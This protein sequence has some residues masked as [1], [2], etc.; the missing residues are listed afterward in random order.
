MDVFVPL[1]GPM[2]KCP[3]SLLLNLLQEVVATAVG[4]KEKRHWKEEL[5]PFRD[6][7]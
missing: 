5:K 2:Q 4:Q 7:L 1:T 6:D 3:L